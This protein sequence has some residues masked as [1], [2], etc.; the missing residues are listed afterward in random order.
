MQCGALRTLSYLWGQAE[1]LARVESLIQA[2]VLRE[3]SVKP[4]G[5]HNIR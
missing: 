5:V 4:R 1:A 3:L 2:K